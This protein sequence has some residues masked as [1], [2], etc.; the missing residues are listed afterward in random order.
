MTAYGHSPALREG[1]A[2][3]GSPPQ[4]SATEGRA[5]R[6]AW[7]EGDQRV[8]TILVVLLVL[9]QRMG[10]PV[11][12][13]TISV[14]LPLSYLAVTILLFRRRLTANRLRSELYLIAITACLATTAIVALDGGSFSMTSL[15]LLVAIYLPW[16]MRARGSTPYAV[17]WRAGA[18]FV[19][20]ML[21]VAAV[22]VLQFAAQLA[23][24]WQ[25]Q[26]YLAQ[27]IPSQYLVFGYNPNIPLV[28]GSPTFKANAF[29][30]LEPSFLSQYCALA[31]VIGMI[32]R[33]PTWQL[34][35]LVA[36]LASAVSGTGIVA[37]AIGGALILVRARHRIRPAYLVGA[38][39]ALV[40]VLLG[41]TAPLLLDRTGEVTQSGTSG[42]ARFVAP[43]TEALRGL[44]D[45][46]ARY[47][48]G[49]GPGSADRLLGER[50]DGR[51]ALANF[52]IA[53]KLAFEY[54][55]I[56]G[57]LFVVFILLGLLDG[58]PW[59]VVPGVLVVML[60]L[61]SGA[62]LQPQTAFLAW[63]LIGLGASDR[64]RAPYP[65]RHQQVPSSASPGTVPPR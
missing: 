47:A 65:S 10:V 15:L 63:V 1:A 31:A 32:L 40:V 28:F 17:A 6:S 60:F 49:A 11:G 61:L 29:V 20:V 8:V 24:I 37:L 59:R 19:R 13:S 3:T 54:G 44:E 52:S 27:V 50:G 56:A 23:G 41:P 34:L 21:V 33:V 64:A 39:V 48:V 55:L 43:I 53:P 22:A 18:T 35:L 4:V 46:P 14:A 36:G 7:G 30:M 62:L 25:Y 2:S 51:S 45:D 16:T 38:V 9:T 58:A 57:G 26:D 5:T 12:G 42:N